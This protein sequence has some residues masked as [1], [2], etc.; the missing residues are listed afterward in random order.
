MKSGCVHFTSRLDGFFSKQRIE[1]DLDAE[2]QSHLVMLNRGKYPARMGPRQRAHAAKR[3]F[4]GVE[5]AKEEYREQRGPAAARR[6]VRGYPL[7]IRMLGKRP[8][9][10]FVAVLTLAI[11]MAPTRRSSRRCTPSFC[12][13]LP[14][15]KRI[16]WRLFGRSLA[17]RSCSCVGT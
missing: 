16:G 12:Q 10:V 8:G 6:L 9:L 1:R 5:Q 11:G 14:F 17:L 15:P 7:C 3:E 4:G 13:S 2:V